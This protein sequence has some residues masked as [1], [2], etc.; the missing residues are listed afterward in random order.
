MSL[1]SRLYELQPELF[2]RNKKSTKTP[3]GSEGG[4]NA[5]RI[6]KLKSK[7][8]NIEKDVLFDQNE[9]EEKWQD[10]LAQLREEAIF[11]AGSSKPTQE[12]SQ[13]NINDS[14]P[15]QAAESGPEKESTDI[16]RSD[17]Q[18]D[19]NDMFAGIFSA[20]EQN[21]TPEPIILNE[22]QNATVK[23]RDFGKSVGMSPRRIFEDAC[24]ARYDHFSQANCIVLVTLTVGTETRH[25]K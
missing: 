20:E 10:Q 14:V 11:K 13:E 15:H 24:R 12:K 25:A 3:P 8:A 7:I 22:L 19:E 5:S 1:R 18:E 2:G 21:Q 23:S 9:A 6:R 16:L 17:V 4:K